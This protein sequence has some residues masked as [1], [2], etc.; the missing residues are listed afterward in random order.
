MLGNVLTFIL[1]YQTFPILFFF[2]LV[3]LIWPALMWQLCIYIL[4]FLQHIL[5]S[6]FFIFEMFF[7]ISQMLIKNRLEIMIQTRPFR[8]SFPRIW[9]INREAK[10]LKV[11]FVCFLLFYQNNC[12]KGNSTLGWVGKILIFFQ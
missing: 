9:I 1:S 3:C 8:C 6:L 5:L 12:V 4:N 7:A 2:W 10:R 11:L